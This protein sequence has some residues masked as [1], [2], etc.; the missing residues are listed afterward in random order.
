MKPKTLTEI[1]NDIYTIIVKL[2]STLEKKDLVEKAR[3]E[4]AIEKLSASLND[5]YE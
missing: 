5:L 3:L 1:R 2:R 4:S